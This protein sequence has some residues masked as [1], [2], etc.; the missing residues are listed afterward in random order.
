MENKQQI[1]FDRDVEIVTHLIEC[2]VKG[3]V[4][5]NH[6]STLNCIKEHFQD[7]I[8][9]IKQFDEY[10]GF[11]FPQYSE[12]YRSD[13]IQT[14]AIDVVNKMASQPKESDN[15]AE[16]F[17]GVFNRKW[18]IL[19]L[20]QEIV[21]LQ[22]QIKELDT[23]E[24]DIEDI[25]N[26]NKGKVDISMDIS[27]YYTPVANGLSCFTPDKSLRKDSIEW[28]SKQSS[29]YCG[30]QKE[31]ADKSTKDV[32]LPTFS[33]EYGYAM[34]Q[35]QLKGK[36]KKLSNQ[37]KRNSELETQ[38]N[39]LKSEIKS[40]AEYNKTL[41]QEIEAW[42]KSVRH[43]IDTN[44]ESNK[45]IIE[46]K[47]INAEHISNGLQGIIPIYSRQQLQQCAQ[48]LLDLHNESLDK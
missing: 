28:L 24:K 22:A 31:T 34:L 44:V 30:N 21:D 11:C 41:R 7:R 20:K 42:K 36:D 1:K 13:Y 26:A 10:K 40:S 25:N 43:W 37:V 4:V 17:S 16:R 5:I 9:S 19:K 32:L 23:P 45:Q 2:C 39:K 48:D 27:N 14:F 29:I 15:K 46:L 3:E 12:K 35:H 33:Y 6:E 47:K 38:N 8:D 18:H